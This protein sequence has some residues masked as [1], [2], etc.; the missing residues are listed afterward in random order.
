V[1]ALL[2]DIQDA[3]PIPRSAAIRMVKE[4]TGPTTTGTR[5][6]ESV[7]VAPLCWLHVESVVSQVHEPDQL[8][9]DFRSRWLT[10][11][12]TYDIEPAPYG[13]ILHQRETVR[14][15]ALP[16]W[17]SPWVER[18]MRPRLMERLTDIKQILEAS[19]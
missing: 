3:E 19:T 7:R 16:R 8:A 12:L 1:F 6:H 4:P 10:G 5:W 11:N 17:L 9:L 14:L 13:S 2:A 15:R 18:R